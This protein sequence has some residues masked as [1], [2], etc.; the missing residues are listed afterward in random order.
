MAR[1]QV[2]DGLPLHASIEVVGYLAVKPRPVVSSTASG[3]ASAP[4]RVGFLA[5]APE[6]PEARRL[7]DDD[8]QGV[9]YVTNVSRLWGHLPQALDG[10]SDLLGEAARAAS[11]TYRQRAVLVTAAASALGDAYCSLAWGKKLAEASSPEMAA[12]VIDGETEGLPDAERALAQWARLVAG[13]PN[14]V[15]EADVDALRRAGFSDDQI[16]AL[17]MFVSLRLAFAT[18]NDALGASPD[19][20]LSDDVPGTVRA[21]VTFGRAQARRTPAA[22]SPRGTNGN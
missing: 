11:L 4:S 17:T 8:L 15:T 6:T 16:F 7:F 21:A 9:G 2:R 12:T 10:L 19:R 13:D 18:V 1:Q 14:A 20:E 22:T 5:T 3:S